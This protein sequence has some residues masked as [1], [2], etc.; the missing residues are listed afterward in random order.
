VPTAAP[1]PDAR[2][3]GRG[4][5]TA[6]VDVQA[7]TRDPAA[8]V[9]EVHAGRFLVARW[10]GVAGEFAAFPPRRRVLGQLHTSSSTRGP[11]NSW[12]RRET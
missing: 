11:L 9:V 8:R 10:D 12:A 5:L 2:T 6:T 1:L 4:V 3:D 7:T